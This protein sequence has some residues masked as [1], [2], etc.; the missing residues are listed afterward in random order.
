MFD[1]T[2]APTATE[3]ELGALSRRLSAL[4]Q[5]GWA[6]PVRCVGWTVADLAA[7]LVGA[8]KGQADG[9]RAASSGRQ[10][11]A[12]LDSPATRDP[13]KLCELL[14]EARAELSEALKGFQPALA[15]AIVPLPFG[16]VP[17]MLALQIVPLE[18]GFH[19]NDLTHALGADTILPPDVATALIQILPG[20]L[21][22]LADGTAVGRPGETPTEAV[23]YSLVC[24][25]GNVALAHD[26]NKWSPFDDAVA[27]CQIAGDDNAVALFAMGRIT[28][29]DRRLHIND[30]PK[31]ER[32]KTWFPGP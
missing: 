2:T 11:L 3:R 1:F 28:A 24:P 4:D 12:V 8:A 5:A 27:A 13:V 22:A 31:A 29:D 18:Y 16:P 26:G 10:E 14:D 15:D 32:F 21:P 7:H 17:A 23:S 9:L 6:K 19:H 20:L 25:S 30:L